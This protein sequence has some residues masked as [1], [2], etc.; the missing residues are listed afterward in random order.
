MSHPSDARSFRLAFRA[1]T[2]TGLLVAQYF[3]NPNDAPLAFIDA[4]SK[5]R[6][7]I[8]HWAVCA[9][10]TARTNNHE[11]VHRAANGNVDPVRRHEESLANG[12]SSVFPN[13][14]A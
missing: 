12:L 7:Q 6:G 8:S 9:P 11:P 3:T 4:P 1:F 13:A 14:I 10:A 2:F 5:C